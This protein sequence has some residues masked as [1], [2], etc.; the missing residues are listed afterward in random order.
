MDKPI[1]EID[2]IIREKLINYQEDTSTGFWLRLNTRLSRPRIINGTILSIATLAGLFFWLMMPKPDVEA[3]I[4]TKPITEQNTT[5]SISKQT[6]ENQPGTN[7]G[8]NSQANNFQV[9]KEQ[10]E[11]S[12]VKNITTPIGVAATTFDRIIVATKQ[13]TNVLNIQNTNLLLHDSNQ[14]IKLEPRLVSGLIPE[15]ESR[16]FIPDNTERSRDDQSYMERSL[17]RNFSISLEYGQGITRKSFGNDPHLQEFIDFRLNNEKQLMN[18]SYGIKFNYHHKNWVV[19][20]GLDYTTLGEKLNYNL[21]ETVIDPEG[22][23]YLYDTI[24]ATIIDPENNMVPMIIGYDIT[25]IEEYK[26]VKYKI[27]NVNRY[28]YIEIPALVGYNFRINQ[29]NV[30]PSIGLTFGFLY[31]AS[32]RLPK[33][34]STNFSV[35][36][37][38]SIYLK[39]I[40]TN[41]VFDLSLEY[42][43]NRKY[44]VFI[45]PYFKK[46]LGSI[47]KNYPLSGSYTNTGVKIGVNIYF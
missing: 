22:G 26:N 44:D 15:E 27:D 25:K 24:W 13:P 36:H 18:S 8:I 12:I 17:F 42:T 1:K 2:E 4:L 40:A 35:I 23:Y 7:S 16:A 11:T 19:S 34:D 38:K 20:T 46:G 9:A 10:I 29:F 43:F 5:K 47:Y 28:S 31:T 45:K 37:D 6:I 14:V 30:H 33:L 39:P 21:E 41:M 3:N 32:G